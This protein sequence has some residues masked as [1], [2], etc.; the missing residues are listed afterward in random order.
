[1]KENISKLLDGIYELEGLLH[2]ALNREVVDS[3]LAELILRKNRQT[4]ESAEKLFGNPKKETKEPEEQK[5][6]KEV[7]T[8]EPKEPEE[9]PDMQEAYEEVEIIEETPE[10]EIQ[11]EEKPEELEI[12][13]EK[14]QVS[15]VEEKKPE[16][17][18][19]EKEEPV[20]PILNIESMEYSLEDED[21][22]PLP[23]ENAK[24]P[25]PK[26]NAVEVPAETKQD[27]EDKEVVK[28]RVKPEIKKPEIRPEFKREETKPKK[29]ST[30]TYSINDRFLFIRELF[31]GDAAAFNK[32][33]EDVAAMDSFE[34]AESYFT[35]EKGFD[36]E[37]D[38]A[39]RFFEI[40]LAYF[41]KR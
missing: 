29:A 28:V 39:V 36:E 9:I 20:K 12:P 37:S 10:E 8:A 22:I 13:E 41:K 21:L 16:P 38:T 17:E 3:H 27:T 15:E 1:M 4:L 30:P 35:D 18:H 25:E 5:K 34:E 14:P 40:L 11:E 33:M 2:L 26:E 7:E 24:S 6:S 23:E 32:A 31:D 19:E